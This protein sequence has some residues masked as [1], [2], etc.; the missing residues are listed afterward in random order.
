VAFEK[1]QTQRDPFKT[2]SKSWSKVA[3]IKGLF[4]TYAL[5]CKRDDGL[6][7]PL[8]NTEFRDVVASLETLGLVHEA[9]GRGSGLLTPTSTPSR[10]GR[11]ADEKQV[12]S[13]VSEREMKDSLNGPGSDLLQRLLDE[14]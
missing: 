2:P 9:L 7:Q 10:N 1:R 8:K 5:L 13:A 6:L 3:T 4:E 14:Q 11:A 12:V